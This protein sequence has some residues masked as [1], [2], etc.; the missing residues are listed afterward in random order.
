MNDNEKDR[1]AAMANAL[2][3]DWPRNSLRSLLDRPELAHRTRRDMA[4]AL[5]WVACDSK[6]KTPARVIEA[7][8][9]WNATN[10]E[11]SATPRPPKR[12]EACG[13]CGRRERDHVGDW[14]GDHQFVPL[15]QPA[16]Q[17]TPMP[18]GF[19]DMTREQE[20]A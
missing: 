2:R 8:P 12:E 16:S 7:G 18:E 19:R 11:G 17:K 9:W 5:A 1:I 14:L 6:T 10:A 4:V 15:G 20:T 3:P 13:T